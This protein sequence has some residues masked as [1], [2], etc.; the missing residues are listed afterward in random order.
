M[1]ED[2]EAAPAVVIPPEVHQALTELSVAA[3]NEV[4]QKLLAELCKR[5]CDKYAAIGVAVTIQVNAQF[6]PRAAPAT[7]AEQAAMAGMAQEPA[8]PTKH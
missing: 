4:T 6:H 3:K 7:E 2:D 8:T 5:F 1:P